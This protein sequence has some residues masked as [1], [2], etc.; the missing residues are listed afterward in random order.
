MSRIYFDHN[1][2]SPLRP[3]VR[4]GL[5]QFLGSSYGNPSSIHGSGRQ[6]RAKIDEAREN[7][8]KLIGANPLDIVFTSSAVE[9][10]HLAWNA[11]QTS[12][13]K[14]ATTS[15]EHPC[16]RGAS[17]KAEIMGATVHQIPVESD[18]S[19]SEKSIEEL[20][21]FRP[22]FFS[23][24]YANNETG[25]LYPVESYVQSLQKFP[26]YFH[27]DAVQA[28]GKVP[29]N[30]K[31]LGIHYLSLSGHK[32]GALQGIG[33]LYMKKG[34][35]FKNL[36][37]GG[38]QEKGLRS[39]TEN[40]L[41]IISMGIAAKTIQSHGDAERKRIQKLRDQFEEGMVRSIPGISIT[42][43]NL[44]RIPNTSHIIF[45]NVD[46]ESL[47]IVCDLEGIDISTGSACSS[48]SIEPSKVVLAMGIPRSRAIGAVRF[49]FG[50]STTEADIQQS[51]E[52]L[53]R[54]VTQV[55][56]THKVD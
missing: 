10:N 34:A 42:A 54:L 39:G 50:W 32:L 19:I 2:T 16:I 35:P 7:V 36:W 8:A 48:G 21:A 14:I 44:D 4:D 43:K 13:K 30:V 27:T 6:I 29:V 52:T 25:V 55:R 45:E 56:K 20:V 41:G 15:T 23:I 9:A 12:G 51:L 33:A 28:V 49:S 24:H 18:G 22:D 37:P 53:P 40:V 38:S 5:V 31:E 1:S 46:A 3:E 47:L 26:C 17:E 11:F